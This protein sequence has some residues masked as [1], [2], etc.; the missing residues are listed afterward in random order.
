MSISPLQIL[1]TSQFK[2]GS[3]AINHTYYPNPTTIHTQTISVQGQIFFNLVFGIICSQ[4]NTSC[5]RHKVDATKISYARSNI[6][7]SKVWT[8]KA[9]AISCCGKVNVYE[10][11]LLVFAQTSNPTGGTEGTRQ[12]YLMD[13]K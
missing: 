6:Q 5:S 11:P 12:Q 9:Y 3:V 2:I 1:S 8:N 10:A 7:P 13:I 4:R